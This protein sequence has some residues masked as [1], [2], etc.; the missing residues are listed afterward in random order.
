[1]KKYYL[2]GFILIALS[3]TVLA[4]SFTVYYNGSKPDPRHRSLCGKAEAASILVKPHWNN[5]SKEFTKLYCP[6]EN[7][8]K[9]VKNNFDRKASSSV[10]YTTGLHKLQGVTWKTDN[11][12]FFIDLEPFDI[13]RVNISMRMSLYANGVC[14]I[15]IDGT[16]KPTSLTGTVV[17]CE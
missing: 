8:M 12:C 6:E 13:S 7:Y 15:D 4:T 9:Y 10:N 14:E 2:I 1:M 17:R 5:S 11:K 16:G 3:Q